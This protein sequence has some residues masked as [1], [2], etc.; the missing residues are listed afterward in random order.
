MILSSLTILNYKSAAA[1]NPETGAAARAS[2]VVSSAERRAAA[3]GALSRRGAP[4]QEREV[5][6]ARAALPDPGC[7]EV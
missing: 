7:P 4:P 2:R 3:A 5:P 6:A 1:H